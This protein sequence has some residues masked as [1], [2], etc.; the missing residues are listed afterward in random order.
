MHHVERGIWPSSDGRGQT[1]G[2]GSRPIY[3]G[4]DSST[5]PKYTKHL[6]GSPLPLNSVLQRVSRKSRA[7]SMF[8]QLEEA[9][10]GRLGGR[11]TR[12]GG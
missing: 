1:P 9:G 12:V 10:R 8:Y 6:T 2:I 3:Q 7:L 4:W 11:K 5:L